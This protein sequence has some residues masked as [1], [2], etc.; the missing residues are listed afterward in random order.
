ML[1][2]YHLL[3]IAVLGFVPFTKFALIRTARWLN[4]LQWFT[5]QLRGRLRVGA[6]FGGKLSWI[7]PDLG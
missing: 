4:L 5:K 2:S 3:Q 6:N 7:P 1:S